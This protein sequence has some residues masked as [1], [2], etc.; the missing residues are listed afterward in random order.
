MLMRIPTNLRAL[1][2]VFAALLLAGLAGTV[3]TALALQYI[4]GFLPCE[5]CLLERIP[6]Y[7]GAAL[8]VFAL[9]ALRFRSPPKWAAVLFVITGLLMLADAALSLY[10]VGV[11]LKY[12]AGPT[13]CSSFALSALPADTN[14]LLANL[15]SLNIIP[16]D[17]PAGYIFGLSFAGWNAVATFA[18]ALFA[19]FAA[20]FPFIWGRKA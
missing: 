15:N 7:A 18:F 16:C 2:A 1:Q 9:A 19:A 17:R 3:A 8:M 11:E 14:A 12:W 13:A 20:W 4:W 5:L 10:H 6:Y